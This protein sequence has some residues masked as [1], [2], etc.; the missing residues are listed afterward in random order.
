[1]TEPTDRDDMVVC[2]KCR[3]HRRAGND[4]CPHCGHE[5]GRLP[6]PNP[7]EDDLPVALY[8]PAP[9]PLREP[10]GVHGEDVPRITL[11]GPPPFSLLE[12]ELQRRRAA[13]RRAVIVAA[14]LAGALA[15]W[16]ILR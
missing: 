6:P 15:L 5:P 9:F 16:W 14:V 11:Y 1:M 3:R 10:K 4:A 12:A 13:R 7:P 2:K 8:G